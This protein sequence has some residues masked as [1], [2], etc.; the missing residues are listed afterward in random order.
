[1][2]NCRVARAHSLNIETDAN[3][4]NLVTLKKKIAEK[5]AAPTNSR[6][7]KPL[8]KNSCR[9]KTKNIRKN[10]IDTKELQPDRAVAL[11]IMVMT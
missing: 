9:C 6:F 1:M 11:I 8:S 4:R 10:I 3:M 5:S 7:R 2:D